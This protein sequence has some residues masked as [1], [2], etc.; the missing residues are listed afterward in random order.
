MTPAR[1]RRT[2]ASHRGLTATAKELR[3]AW[4]NS[5]EFLRREWASGLTTLIDFH[6]R[7]GTVAVMVNRHQESAF[8][9]AWQGDA[10]SEPC[11]T[12]ADA[13]TCAHDFL[14]MTPTSTPTPCTAE[15][16]CAACQLARHMASLADS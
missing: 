5:S 7:E 3:Q 1:T 15:N 16:P 4:R 14:T 8:F 6:H 9:E 11:Y 10:F 2:R 12:L 13:L